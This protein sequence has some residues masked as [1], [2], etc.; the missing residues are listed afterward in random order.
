MTAVY[1][2]ICAL[3][4][5]AAALSF[6]ALGMR[7]ANENNKKAWEKYYEGQG[8]KYAHADYT[9]ISAAVVPFQ[10]AARRKAQ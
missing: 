7:I 5:V 2:L 4:S 6:I 8:K 1:F 9:G 3:G 10:P